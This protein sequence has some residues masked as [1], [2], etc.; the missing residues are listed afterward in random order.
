[1]QLPYFTRTL[2]FMTAGPLI[3]AVHFGFIYIL[4]A[5]VCARPAS[6]SAWLSEGVLV[7][8]LGFASAMAVALILWITLRGFKSGGIGE[9]RRFVEWTALALGALS[10]YA[11][12]LE[13]LPVLFM[14][15]CA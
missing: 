10:I 4:T 11:I 8:L 2:L 1:M 14:P 13:T 3:W 15:A 12:V 7:W 9:N 5:M 6:A